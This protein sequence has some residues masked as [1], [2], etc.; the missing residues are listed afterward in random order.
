MAYLALA[1]PELSSEDLE[2]IQGYR[3]QHDELYYKVVDPHFTLVFP[4]TDTP[5]EV[6]IEEVNERA[7]GFRKIDFVIRCATINKDAFSEYYHIFLVP[8]KGYSKI[9]K[10]HDSLYRGILKD[11]LRLD[12]DFIPHIGVGNSKDRFLCKKLVDQWN[13][14]EFSIRGTISGLTVVEYENGVVTDLVKVRLK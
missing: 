8:D 9:I 7:K 12:I 13:K 1:Y 10:L 3:Q 14:K 6:F 2:S 11:N 5:K 4:V